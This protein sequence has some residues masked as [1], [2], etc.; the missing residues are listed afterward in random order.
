MTTQ[1]KKWAWAVATT[2]TAA[3]SIGLF[4]SISAWSAD[5]VHKDE[6]EQ[7][8]E[9][10]TNVDAAVQ[11]IIADGKTKELE[12]LKHAKGEFW[13]QADEALFMFWLARKHKLQSEL[14]NSIQP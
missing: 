2:L 11:Y 8:T 14:F 3:G 9:Q 4:N 12:A 10:I 1:I 7:V 5:L 13:T 6:L